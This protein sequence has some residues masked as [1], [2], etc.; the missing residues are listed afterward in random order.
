MAISDADFEAANRRAMIRLE[1]EPRAVAAR[2]DRVRRRI[3]IDLSTGAEVS[4]PPQKLQ[5][6]DG[7]TPAELSEI[8]ISPT[9]CGLY[10]PKRDADFALDGLLAGVFGSRKWMA[11]QLGA[12]GGKAVSERKA[13]ASRN[14][15]KLG[16]RPKKQARA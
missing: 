8:E 11:A 10:F 13:Q 3:V 15:G 2:Y 9:G 16:G 4:F 14:N 5:G 1:H 6:L 7:A 12:R